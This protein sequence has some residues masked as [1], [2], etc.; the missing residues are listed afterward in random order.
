MRKAVIILFALLFVYPIVAQERTG[1]IIGKVID[2]DGNPLPGVLDGDVTYG[3]PGGIPEPDAPP[4]EYRID[5]SAQALNYTMHYEPGTL[6]IKEPY[7][8]VITAR[9]ESRLYGEPNPAWTASYLIDES[10]RA[11]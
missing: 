11:R 3:A 7:Q 10:G 5:P 9:D 8:L 6:L 2:Q 4:G 1:R